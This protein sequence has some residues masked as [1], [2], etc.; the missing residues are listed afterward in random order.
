M[1]F[2]FKTGSY[3]GPGITAQVSRALEVRTELESR[4]KMPGMWDAA[5][6][7]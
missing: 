1:E 3:D 6:A 2:V 7:G 4:A 5:P